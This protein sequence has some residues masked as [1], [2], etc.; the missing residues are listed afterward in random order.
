MS[1]EN[2]NN[3]KSNKFYDGTTNDVLDELYQT[4]KDPLKDSSILKA[5]SIAF[6]NNDSKTVSDSNQLEENGVSKASSLLDG[7]LSFVGIREK[8]SEKLAN[9]KRK[10]RREKNSIDQS[11]SDLKRAQFSNKG[12]SQKPSSLADQNQLIDQ[13]VKERISNQHTEEQIGDIIFN[14]GDVKG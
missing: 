11:K 7:I 5:D 13:K 10:D 4:T 14:E 9:L 2:I 12:K 6:K 1:V 8:K 3:Q